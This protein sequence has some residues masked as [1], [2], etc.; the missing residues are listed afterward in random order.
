MARTPPQPRPPPSSFPMNPMPDVWTVKRAPF[1][2]QVPI[3]RSSS[4]NSIYRS[5]VG[6]ILAAE[7][8]P[9]TPSVPSFR[10]PFLAPSSRPSSSLWS[11]PTY[12][13]Q[14]VSSANASTTALPH[15]SKPKPPLP[16]TRLSGPIEKSDKPW[17]SSR[18][19]GAMASYLTTLLFIF[20]G[21][22]GAAVLCWQG[23]TNV[24]L[25]DQS[26]L[27][28]VLSEDFSSQDLDT[29][30]WNKDIELGGFGNGEFEMT[31]DSSS[32]LFISNNQLYIMPTLTS[33]VISSASIFNGANYTLEGCTT[34]NTSACTVQSN[35]LVGSVI[36]PVQSAR[37]NTQGKKN[38][39]YGKVEVRAKLPR[40]YALR[41]YVL[42]YVTYYFFSDWL[43]PAIWMLPENNTYGPWPASGEIDIMEAR[44]NGP[45]YP[46]QGSNY[47]RSTLNYGPLP[48]VF[49]QIFGWL[50]FFLFFFLFLQLKSHPGFGKNV[51]HSTKPSTPTH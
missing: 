12:N 43:W 44:G 48:T 14:L 18:E 22:G 33:D 46:A 24:L 8:R 41:S 15:L 50:V 51:P 7:S 2:E 37:I 34:S 42:P 31:T 38:I 6:A 10:P 30:T 11:P 26:K 13:S 23:V 40:G 16:S 21:L 5:S 47:V 20:L 9:S 45:T 35:S 17:L 25:I 3:S 4:S 1:M 28:S 29:S 39:R 36:N 32:N 27:C 49:N 19:P